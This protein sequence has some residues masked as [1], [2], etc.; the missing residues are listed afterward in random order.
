M[1]KTLSLILALLMSAS[2]A[3]YILADEADVETTAAI[4]EDA[5]VEEV[6]EEAEEVTEYDDALKFL[7]LKNIMHGMEDGRLHAELG[8]ERYQMALFVGRVST[9]W[10][11]DSQW[12]DGIANDS[13]FKDL[14]GTAAE[15]V[16][17]AIS[18]VN[19]K[20]IIEG[21]EDGSFKPEKGVT[22]REALTMAVRTLEY[23]GLDYPW[24]YI[25]K[26]IGLGLTDGISGVAYTDEIDR[27]VAAQIVYNMLFADTKSGDTL[28]MRSFGVDFGWQNIIV[29]A[30]NKNTY[31]AGAKT[32]TNAGV[33]AFKVIN[34]DGTLGDETYYLNEDLAV[35]SMYNALFEINGN[36]DYVDVVGAHEYVATVI[37]N[38]GLTD[39]EGVAYDDVDAIGTFLKDYTLVDKYGSSILAN[40]NLYRNELIVASA[41]ETIR[42]F[43]GKVDAS[44]T[45]YAFNWETGDILVKVDD[46]NNKFH[47][48]VEWFYNA[49]YDYYF[50]YTDKVV[51][52]D[53]ETVVVGIDIMDAKDVADLKDAMNESIKVYDDFAA[54]NKLTGVATTAYAAL[55]TYDLNG[56]DAADYA[57]YEAYSLAKFETTKAKCDKCNSDKDA[58]QF[59]AYNLGSSKNESKGKYIA[60]GVCDHYSVKDGK[61]GAN[62]TKAWTFAADSIVPENGDVVIY[63]ANY[64]T[65]ELKVVK[66]VGKL[67]ENTD[68]DSYIAR[69]VVRGYSYKNNEV[70][71]GDDNYKYDY[72]TLAGNAF[73]K[74]G[75]NKAAYSNA[76]SALLNQY[77]EY[78]VV[79]GKLVYVKTVGN[80]D[81]N[82]IVVESF[83]GIDS[84]GYIVV[85]GYST[86]DLAY[87]QFRI[88]SYDNWVRGDFFSNPKQVKAQFVK[89]TVYKITS[90]DVDAENGT[91]YYV[92]TLSKAVKENGDVTGYEVK[93]DTKN[94]TITFENGYR[95]IGDNAKK[96][97]GDD[98]YIIIGD[99]KYTDKD[100]VVKYMPIYVFEGKVTNMDW[101]VTG[102]LLVG[103]ADK[104]TF[105]IVNAENINGFNADTTKTGFVAVLKKTI[106]EVNYNGY[107]KDYYIYGQTTYTVEVFNLLTGKK[108]ESRVGANIDLEAGRIYYTIDDTIIDIDGEQDM[109][110]SEFV[111][112]AKKAYADYD[113]DTADY[114]FFTIKK[115]NTIENVDCFNKENFSKE[116]V[117]GELFATQNIKGEFVAP[118]NKY[119]DLVSGLDVFEV[120]VDGDKVTAIDSINA[121]GF[122]KNYTAKN[123]TVDAFVVYNMKTQKAVVYLTND[124]KVTTTV[125]TDDVKASN[126]LEVPAAVD[127]DVAYIEATANVETTKVGSKLTTAKINGFTFTFA[128][129]ATNDTH[130]AVD[131][132]NFHFGEAGVCD[133]ENWNTTV[134]GDRVFGSLEAGCYDNHDDEADCNLIKTIEVTFDEAVELKVPYTV[135]TVKFEANEVIEST[136]AVTTTTYELVVTAHKD[137]NN[138]KFY[139]EEANGESTIGDVALEIAK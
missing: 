76:L 9:G 105:I 73:V 59:V 34:E 51:N 96:V 20:G 1:K 77:V 68:A 137:G 8:V 54:Y 114:R 41:N 40:S 107:S 52:K 35:G 75:D 72:A 101:T 84:D 136:G 109:N 67:G 46:G 55:A 133:I 132:D 44:L 4:E 130:H 61:V 89:G 104:S 121:D 103:G 100:N 129:A 16:Y 127:E 110:W 38:K 30:N 60:E 69:G 79:D 93:A 18:Y 31:E 118:A 37:E 22:Y 26:A 111:A 14:A 15:N 124:S 27:G 81:S 123:I 43:T 29:T 49:E 24:G 64:A 82:Y 45:K 7:T 102:D 119:K 58:Y 98:K 36:N 62:Y 25:E 85:N 21:Y 32:T 19:Q 78:I 33:S 88:G 5:V 116:Y 70:T 94:V 135:F 113:L 2:C 71:I 95:V 97:S 47:Y 42:A 86:N 126:K 66:V 83:A 125:K 122:A 74:V 39:D 120:T 17:G 65:N 87:D 63:G 117:T 128:G 48:E 115:F 12:E 108:D 90:A 57:T 11:V 139:F 3:S 112:D 6:A 91:I 80:T 92:E 138:V 10:V 13:Q 131:Y 134:N 50:N 23:Q 28:A 99:D 106:T 56:D 53:G